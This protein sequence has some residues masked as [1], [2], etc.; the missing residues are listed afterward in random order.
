MQISSSLINNGSRNSIYGNVNAGDVGCFC[1]TIELTISLQPN[2]FWKAV[3]DIQILT[4]TG[5]DFNILTVDGQ[6]YVSPL[7]T[8]YQLNGSNSLS[9]IV[10]ICN[11]KL[12]TTPIDPLV[13]WFSS[14]Y[15]R[16]YWDAGFTTGS[17]GVYT[18]SNFQ[19]IDINDA[20]TDPLLGLGTSIGTLYAYP[21]STIL[22]CN[23][24]IAV[25]FPAYNFSNTPITF[26]LTF[27]CLTTP[28][29]YY[30]DGIA[31]SGNTIE[32]PPLTN[33]K[34]GL[35]FCY[36]VANVC[37]LSI[38]NCITRRDVDINIT[39]VYCAPAGSTGF[40]CLDLV[41]STN[42]GGISTIADSISYC[43]SDCSPI[44]DGYN[45]ASVGEEKILKH[46]FAYI[47]G[48][49]PGGVQVWYNPSLY[50]QYCD[51]LNKYGVSIDT[52]PTSGYY[53]NIADSIIGD[54]NYYDMVQFSNQNPSS[55]PSNKNWRVQIKIL[56]GNTF[57]IK[58]TFYLWSD[59]D[60]WITSSVYPNN[61]KL[62]YSDTTNQTQL[63]TQGTVYS[64]WKSICSFVFIKDPN[65]QIVYNGIKQDYFNYISKC[66]P[67]TI[68]HWNKGLYYNN[69][70]A[71][72][73]NPQFILERGSFQVNNFSNVS[74]TKVTFRITN[75]LGNPIDDVIFWLW[76]KN[77][78]DNISDF[79]VATDSSRATL[80]NDPTTQVLNNH[81]ET[82][83]VKPT[84][85]STNRYEC[86]CYV[87]NNLQPG[88]EY[89]IGAIV[90]SEND[91]IVNSFLSPK[92]F[93]V[94][95][96]IDITDLCCPLDVSSQLYD[97][98]DRQ[99]I[100]C[101]SPILKER[102]GQKLNINPGNFQDCLDGLGIGAPWY[103]FLTDIKLN[104]YRQENYYAG[105]PP[106][107][108]AQD[109]LIM[110]AQYQ[111][112][113]NPSLT[114]SFLNPSQDFICYL[115]G[116]TIT[117][118]WIGRV[119][120]EDIVVPSSTQCF[121]I[122][123]ANPMVRSIAGGGVSTWLQNNNITYNW[124]D[125]D[126]FF[127]YI[128]RFDLTSYFGTPT[129]INF[130]WRTRIHPMN[131][132]TNPSP[133]TSRLASIEFYGHNN[134]LSELLNTNFPIC[135]NKY[136]YIEVVIRDN[137][138]GLNG[139]LI[140]FLDKF[141]YGINTLIEADDTAFPTYLPIL[142]NAAI[143]DI[144]SFNVGIAS[145]KINPAALEPGKYQICGAYIDSI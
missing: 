51:P 100:D 58:H 41:L 64:Q 49:T 94:D 47:N 92:F 11:Y 73:T 1:P 126:I 90:Y 77:P 81:L 16:I 44:P 48:F 69:Y 88:E 85:I 83:S 117:T 93:P 45:T 131:Y 123:P 129:A 82:P 8:P 128:F 143:Y 122:D 54:G 62:L 95:G 78:N 116:N 80:T 4:P 119:R 71:E 124:A 38:E 35:G 2:E 96:T 118:N 3:T 70:V 13:S 50:E 53:F 135:I 7:A 108:P 99:T 34:I 102:I 137:G 112:T 36:D 138:D 79:F 111:S 55:I 74:R 101:F 91:Q 87:D 66:V 97:L 76:K 67:I 42:T 110:F 141:P 139:P 65:I 14:G 19:V 23:N 40:D 84:L 133:F 5:T 121:F 115:L 107:I 10:S 20:T 145:F 86:S 132:E 105:N 6:P 37:T 109:V 68:R 26:D 144:S 18:L 98:Y 104:I 72:F 28:I 134:S 12:A 15:I 52:P 9:V 57:E 25:E 89:C 136:E 106:A 127:E 46:S 24:D 33:T 60:N 63:V 39:P 30:I 75:P 27:S 142:N 22:G 32:L 130:V 61:N 103:S 113:F 43:D 59:L 17:Q 31:I 29:T 125:K 120:Y 21:C 114:G 140:A 56:T